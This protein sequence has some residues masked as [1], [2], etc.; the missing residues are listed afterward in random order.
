MHLNLLI[1]QLDERI[2]FAFQPNFLNVL[3][4]S[5]PSFELLTDR[6]GQIER[7]I[8]FKFFSRKNFIIAL[9]EKAIPSGFELK[10]KVV[11]NYLAATMTHTG[12]VN[13]V[14]RV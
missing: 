8:L 13:H 6:I 11:Q 10:S 2:E 1:K 9:I 14:H 4:T 7:R 3:T 12:N 5:D